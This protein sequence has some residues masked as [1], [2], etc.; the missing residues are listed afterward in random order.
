MLLAGVIT[1]EVGSGVAGAFRG[2]MVALQEALVFSAGGVAEVA[3]VGFLHTHERV[4]EVVQ[5]RESPHR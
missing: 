1:M 3:G 5:S 2:A 4:V